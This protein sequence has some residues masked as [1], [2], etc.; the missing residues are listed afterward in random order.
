MLTP[1]SNYGY[2]YHT[3]LVIVQLGLFAF[4]F[5]HISRTRPWTF[6]DIIRWALPEIMAGAVEIQRRGEREADEKLRALEAA[7]YP[8]KGA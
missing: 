7:K 2:R 5:N 1:L 8:A 6:L 3:I 4:V